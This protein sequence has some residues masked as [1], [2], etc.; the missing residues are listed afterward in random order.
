MR[1][2]LQNEEA[3]GIMVEASKRIAFPLLS[4]DHHGYPREFALE[5]AREAFETYESND[6]EI[7]LILRG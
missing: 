2:K 7:Y 4:G 6:L 1:I 5:C 3:S